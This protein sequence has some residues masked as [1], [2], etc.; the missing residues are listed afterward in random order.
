MIW[1]CDKWS[2]IGKRLRSDESIKMSSDRFSSKIDELQSV[3]A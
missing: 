1:T 3:F 2:H